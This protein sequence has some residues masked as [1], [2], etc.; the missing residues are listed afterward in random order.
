LFDAFLATAIMS[1][2]ALSQPQ[3]EKEQSTFASSCLQ[4]EEKT[5]IN[6]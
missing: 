5:T 4:G 3:G 6:L 1:I 2:I